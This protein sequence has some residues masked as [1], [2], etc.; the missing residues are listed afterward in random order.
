MAEPFDIDLN[1]IKKEIFDYLSEEN[2][3]TIYQGSLKT[4]EE[5]IDWKRKCFWS[6]NSNY[7][8]FFKVAKFIG[9]KIIY[10]DEEY[11]EGGDEIACL[12]FEFIYNDIFHVLFIS[13][14]KALQEANSEEAEI[15]E[16][17]NKEDLTLIIPEDELCKRCKKERRKFD[18]K[19]FCIK[20]I[21]ELRE[22]AYEKM[23]QFRETLSKDEEF[24]NLPNEN[25]RVLYVEKKYKEENKKNKFIYLK[26]L[27]KDAFA[28]YKTHK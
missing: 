26:K 24:T 17:K 28:E 8:D 6:E 16:G 9:A 13:S 20:C 3:F 15:G 14:Q 25:A 7:K 27:A 5:G 10:F 4:S 19:D 21:E 12:Q 2:S 22:E 18:D 11:L 1:K 23:K